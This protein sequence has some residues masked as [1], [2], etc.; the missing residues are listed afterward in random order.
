MPLIR[1]PSGGADVPQ[2]SSDTALRD[3]DADERWSA[4]RSLTS[5]GDVG[6]LAAALMAESDPRVREAILTSLARIGGVESVEA[7][8]PHI[9]SDDASLRTAALD[10]LRAMPGAVAASLP[11]LLADA[12]PDVRLLA[13]ELVRAMSGRDA[14]RLL[15]DLIGVDPEPNV[16]ASAVDVLAEVGGPEAAGALDACAGRFPNEPFLAFAIKV[17]KQ[18]ITD[19]SIGR[20]A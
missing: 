17:A 9:R 8:T 1:K 14:T 7:I 6:A 11:Q 5:P 18:R 2:V 3:G 15:C 4:A 20:I 10:S 16:C 19:Q 12:D 13:C